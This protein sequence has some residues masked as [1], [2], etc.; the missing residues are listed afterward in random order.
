SVF[1]VLSLVLVI[2]RSLPGSTLFPYTTLFRSSRAGQAGRYH[3]RWRFLQRWLS[4]AARRGCL[5]QGLRHLR[6][7]AGEPGRAAPRR[8]GR[9][10]RAVTALLLDQHLGLARGLHEGTA[11]NVWRLLAADDAQARFHGP[12]ALGAVRQRPVPEQHSRCVTRA[13]DD[14]FAVEP[15]RLD[16][17][18]TMEKPVP[19][20]HYRT[21]VRRLASLA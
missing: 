20:R 10:R 13:D 6:P 19:A 8:A 14:A 16:R 1:R 17:D 12:R 21:T 7:R 9:H 11:R 2:T 18:G 4:G 3:R 15:A 5:D